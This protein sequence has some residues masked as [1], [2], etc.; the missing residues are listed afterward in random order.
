[1]IIEAILNNKNDLVEGTF[2]YELFENRV[3]N[4]HLFIELIE[5]I[6]SCLI[7]GDYLKDD[8]F[9]ELLEFVPWFVMNTM[10]CVI[11]HNDKN[12]SYFIENMNMSLWYERYENM[13]RDILSAILKR[14]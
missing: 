5:N 1:M 10:H 14:K 7:E 6:T 4:E 12:D 11:C 8:D 13:L 3:F 2:C 9:I